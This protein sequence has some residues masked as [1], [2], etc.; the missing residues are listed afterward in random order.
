M[1][2]ATALGRVPP[3]MKVDKKKEK[4]RKTYAVSFNRELML[5]LQHL[6][7]DEDKFVNDLLEEATEDLLK[8]YREK[9]R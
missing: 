1:T 5:K 7:L 3:M 2:H 9:A 6:A 4:P 8:K